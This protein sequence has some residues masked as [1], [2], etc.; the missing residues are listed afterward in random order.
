[1]A[2]KY[3]QT[4]GRRKTATAQVRIFPGG[5][6]KI[7]INNK[8]LKEYFPQVA[9]QDAVYAPLKQTG[10]QESV[11]ITVRVVGGGLTGQ[12]DAIKMGIARGLVKMDET[13]K[14][15]VKASGFLT[16]DARKK[17]RKKFGLHGAR[18]APQWRKR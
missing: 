3:Y 7:T 6:G 12:S 15:T 18:R 9:M 8:D 10:K 16:R 2:E 1:M 17:E 4:I 5:S 13:L 11:D 14:E